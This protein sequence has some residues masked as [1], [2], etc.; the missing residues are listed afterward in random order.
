[1]DEAEILQITAALEQKSEHPL[2]EAIIQKAGERNTV[3]TEVENFEAMPG[4]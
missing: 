1:M 4:R 3:I 2:A